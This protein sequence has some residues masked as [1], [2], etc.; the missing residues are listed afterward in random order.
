MI[1]VWYERVCHKMRAAVRGYERVCH[2]MTA[3]RRIP[4]CS[5]T[6]AQ[7][8]RI[9]RAHLREHQRGWGTVGL[10]I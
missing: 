8:S 3:T 7:C 2:K 1:G 6:A 9:A 10:A 4:T 5:N